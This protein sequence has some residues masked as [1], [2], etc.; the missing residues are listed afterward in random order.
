[1]MCWKCKV[2]GKKELSPEWFAK[3][4]HF[5]V[6]QVDAVRDRQPSQR[7]LQTA[8]GGPLHGRENS[9]P[10]TDARQ[11]QWSHDEAPATFPQH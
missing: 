6:F 11:Q 3:N 5:S 4:N 1:M 8:T 7:E 2:P 9:Q 10:D